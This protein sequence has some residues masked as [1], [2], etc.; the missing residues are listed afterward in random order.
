[1]ELKK[2]NRKWG[3]GYHDFHA[4]LLTMYSI[5]YATFDALYALNKQRID[6][7]NYY[8]IKEQYFLI[9]ITIYCGKSTTEHFV[10]NQRNTFCKTIVNCHMSHPTK[11]FFWFTIQFRNGSTFTIENINKSIKD[12]AWTNRWKVALFGRE[13]LRNTPWAKGLMSYGEFYL[14]FPYFQEIM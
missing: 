14:V 12:G 8:V 13:K 10:K 2:I 4:L 1:M 5:E 6:E 3:Y 9:Q 11:I 7:N